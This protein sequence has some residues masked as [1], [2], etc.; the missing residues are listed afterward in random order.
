MKGKERGKNKEHGMIERATYGGSHRAQ[1]KDR[2]DENNCTPQHRSVQRSLV[3][4][5]WNF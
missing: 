3:Y 1:K 4:L 5:A 2:Q